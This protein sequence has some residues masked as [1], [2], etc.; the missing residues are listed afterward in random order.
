MA[1]CIQVTPSLK[2]QFAD[3]I[4]QRTAIGV[5]KYGEPLTTFN[6]HDAGRDALEEILDFCQYQHQ[7]LLEVQADI[8]ELISVL[9]K[10]KVDCVPCQNKILTAVARPG[11]AAAM[12]AGGS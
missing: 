10:I 7:Q 5:A 4:D 2:Q 6:G 8:R 9:R 3:W 11:V 12:A 1:D